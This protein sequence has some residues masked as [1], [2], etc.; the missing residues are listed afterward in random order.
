MNFGKFYSKGAEILERSLKGSGEDDYPSARSVRE[1]FP[2][3]RPS[4]E[5]NCEVCVLKIEGNTFP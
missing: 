3:G 5:I 1:S 2:S 4:D